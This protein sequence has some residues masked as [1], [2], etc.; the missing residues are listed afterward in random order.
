MPTTLPGF[1]LFAGLLMFLISLLDGPLTYKDMK[2]PS[3]NHR[4]RLWV[5]VLGIA[6]MVISAGLYCLVM[7][8][9]LESVKLAPPPPAP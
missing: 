4:A 9:E 1:L 7:L 6:F 5:R 3:L 8:G 2:L